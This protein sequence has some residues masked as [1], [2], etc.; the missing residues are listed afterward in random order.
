MRDNYGKAVQQI[1]ET[2]ERWIKL[3][4]SLSGRIAIMKMV[5]LPCFLFLFVN[6]RILLPHAF[7]GQLQSLLVWLA[8]AGKQACVSWDTLM[9][10]VG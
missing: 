6:I 4:P 5:V 10:W 3:P 8:W 9:K 7:F 1:T 2:T